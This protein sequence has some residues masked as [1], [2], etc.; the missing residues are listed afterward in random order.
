MLE[1]LKKLRGLFGKDTE[2]LVDLL[3][4]AGVPLEVAEE[5]AE[6]AKKKS[7]ASVLEERLYEGSFDPEELLK[8]ARPAAIM[9]VGINGTGKTTTAAKI[10]NLLK[11]K[12]YS[13]V[14]AAADTY[15]A[16]AIEQLEEHAKRLGIRVVKHRYGADPA[17]VARDAVEHAKARGIDFVIVD[18]SGRLHTKKGLMEELK[19]IKKVITENLVLTLAVIDATTGSDAVEEAR[20]FGE[21]ADGFVVAKFDADSRGG[22]LLALGFVT[23]K[24]VFFLGTGQDYDALKPFRKEEIIKA[25]V[26]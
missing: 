10:A 20:V 19:K 25:I 26:G 21:L 2:E 18:T 24:P 15:R 13:V 6:E 5:I 16:G 11:K 14:F 17:A 7:L 23:T 1:F 22:I 9:I 3:L 12:G 8:K 4:E